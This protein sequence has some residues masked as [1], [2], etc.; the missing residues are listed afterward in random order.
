MNKKLE[1]S[2]IHVLVRNTCQHSQ[3][4][5]RW[6][7]ASSPSATLAQHLT[8][9]G[10]TPCVCWELR[11]AGIVLLITVGDDYKSTP[12]QCPLNVGS[13]S[14]VLASIHSVLVSTSCWGTCMFVLFY[15]FFFQISYI[16]TFTGHTIWSTEQKKTRQYVR[17][18][19]KLKQSQTFQKKIG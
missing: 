17:S 7:N 3:Q 15:N 9:T 12:T 1:M 11:S 8:S 14:P 13:A 10:S 16:Y 2:A 5:Q 19:A 6:P 18:L 4:T